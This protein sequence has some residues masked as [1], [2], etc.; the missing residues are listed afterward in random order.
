MVGGR[1]E[2]ICE[3]FI[4]FSEKAPIS[5]PK[6]V[7]ILTIRRNNKVFKEMADFIG[8][9]D[10]IQCRSHHVKLLRTHKQIRKIIERLEAPRAPAPA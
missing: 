3:F 4:V 8:T 1:A 2:K 5:E 9:R 6:E 7:L 10:G